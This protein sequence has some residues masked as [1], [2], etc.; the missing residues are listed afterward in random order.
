MYRSRYQRSMQYTKSFARAATFRGTKRVRKNLQ[1]VVICMHISLQVS[2]ERYIHVHKIY[3]KP[4]WTQSWS[5]SWEN[6]SFTMDAQ[7][8][9]PVPIQRGAY[10][11]HMCMHVLLTCNLEL[12]TIVDRHILDSCYSAYIY[13]IV[14]TV[15]QWSVLPRKRAAIFFPCIGHKWMK[16]P[17]SKAGQHNP[18]IKLRGIATAPYSKNS[19][20]TENM[21]KNLTIIECTGILTLLRFLIYYISSFVI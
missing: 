10:N 20:Y 6:L 17:N 18:S 11:L 19:A 7:M 2:R 9:L 12:F 8:C 1:W 21:T 3:L 4:F 16:S 15:K 5:L 13:S 14:D